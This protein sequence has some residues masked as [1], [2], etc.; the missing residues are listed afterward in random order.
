MNIKGLTK[1]NKK[2]GILALYQVLL[3]L[4]FGITY[5]FVSVYVVNKYF[6]FVIKCLG[7]E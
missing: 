7:C 5:S 2:K 6:T 1:M 3:I 4:V